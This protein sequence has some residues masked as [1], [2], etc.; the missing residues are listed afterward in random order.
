MND[1]VDSDSGSLPTSSAAADIRARLRD[2]R[3]AALDWLDE[4]APLDIIACALAAMANTQG[5]T[6]I[7]GVRTPDAGTSTD[8]DAAAEPLVI[9]GVDDAERA[10]GRIMEAALKLTPPLIIPVPQAI[11]LDDKQVVV[12]VVAAGMPRVY[13]LDGRYLRREG[14]ANVPIEPPALRRLLIE[15]GEINFE[16]EPLLSASPDDLDWARVRAYV[17]KLSGIGSA[18][19]QQV[20]LRR[21]CL[22]QHQGKLHPTAAGLLL[23]GKEPQRF[24]RGGDITAVRFAGP[25]MSDTFTREDISGTLPD[26]ISRAETFLRDNMRRDV[27]LGQSMARSEQPEYPLEAARELLVNAVAHRDYSIQGDGIRL[28][29]FSDRMD[30]TSP[31]RLPGPVTVANIKDERFSRNPAIVQVLA[32][33]GYIERLGYG[34]DRVIELA[35]QSG[36]QEPVFSETDG[37]FRARLFNQQAEKPASAPAAPESALAAIP[38]DLNPRQQAAL[39]HLA[40]PNRSRITNSELQRQFPDVHAETIRRDL[41]DMVTR[42]LLSKRG[43]K[44]GS[45]YVLTEPDSHRQ[46]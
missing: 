14:A 15:R 5:G 42:G 27:A 16:T 17:G 13:A 11:T 25:T 40:Q 4:R 32:D 38:E 34:V 33:M 39:E 10:A 22:A 36:L 9:S 26:Q 43:Q 7:V 37:G 46:K 2:G 29:L 8:G 31:G 30:V 45:Y 24:L 28:F 6:L 20:L 1:P 21:G 23:F 3:S 35:R 18:D 19:P 41:A 12:A 44:R